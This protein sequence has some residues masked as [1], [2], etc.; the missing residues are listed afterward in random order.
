MCRVKV[1]RPNV[2]LSKLTQDDREFL[3]RL[4]YEHFGHTQPILI[5]VICSS[6]EEQRRI[7]GLTGKPQLGSLKQLGVA[8]LRAILSHLPWRV[9]APF[10]SS[11]PPALV[12]V[13]TLLSNCTLLRKVLKSVNEGAEPREQRNLVELLSSCWIEMQAIQTSESVVCLSCLFLLSQACS[14]LDL[15]SCLSTFNSALDCSGI[16]RR[17]T[18]FAR[19]SQSTSFVSFLV[20][21]R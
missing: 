2:T 16:T 9:T 11:A 15:W 21:P 18:R 5:V 4:S 1:G 12:A 8:E 14:R 13:L 7:L 10:R 20:F 17:S 19:P 6:L 3:C